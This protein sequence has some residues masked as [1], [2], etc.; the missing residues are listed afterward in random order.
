ME[1]IIEMKD[2]SIKGINSK[3]IE[4]FLHSSEESLSGEIAKR[5][6]RLTSNLRD[7]WR[8]FYKH[9]ELHIATSVSYAPFVET[10][11]GLFGPENTPIV[12]VTARA[13]HA[14]IKGED[15]FFMSSKGQEGAHMAEKG[16]E[17]FK[18]KVPNLFMLALQHTM[19]TTK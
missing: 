14:N 8:P 2:P 19:Q 1:I 7:S 3:T 4:W 11:T 6:P 9:N 16:A 15:V 10:G 13:L 12:P 5:T 17:A 18:A